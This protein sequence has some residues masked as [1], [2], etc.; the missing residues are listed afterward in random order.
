M[1]TKIVTLRLDNTL[2]EGEHLNLSV[3]FLIRI[4]INLNITNLPI[5]RTTVFDR[6]C[7]MVFI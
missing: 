4:Y 3:K 7:K 1:K 6:M 2:A 5:R